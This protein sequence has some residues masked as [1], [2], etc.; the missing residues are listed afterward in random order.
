MSN[1]LNQIAARN[2]INDQSLLMPAN[3]PVEAGLNDPFDRVTM[4]AG[5]TGRTTE[6]TATEMKD[7]DR[8]NEAIAAT[9]QPAKE[10]VK[11]TAAPVQ[12]IKP[13]YLSKY[14]ERNHYHSKENMHHVI[15]NE[16][17]NNKV[18]RVEDERPVLSIFPS[19]KIIPATNEM[20]P[21]KVT[22]AQKSGP[23]QQPDPNAPS[24]TQ[25]QKSILPKAPANKEEQPVAILPAA[26]ATQQDSNPVLLQPHAP[27]QPV[28]T[29]QKEKPVPALVIGKL[30]VEIVPAQKPVNKIINHVVKPQPAP[31]ASTQRNKSS[32]G[33][34]Q[35]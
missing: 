31:P 21:E 5:E 12:P 26:N 2:S 14:G 7:L 30:T 23:V 24:L 6:S 27:L 3:V 15:T 1:Y 16:Q 11:E 22:P 34:G 35:L 20:A 8:E 19:A 28:A 13:V 32:F 18:V 10:P 4:A 17:D 29:Q 33:L 25:T 9:A